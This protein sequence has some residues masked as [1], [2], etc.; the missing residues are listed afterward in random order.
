MALSAGLPNANRT[1]AERLKLRGREQRQLGRCTTPPAGAAA[2]AAA[3][4]LTRASPQRAPSAAGQ[5]LVRADGP[6]SLCQAR[7]HGRGA[8]VRAA[9]VPARLPLAAAGTGAG[10]SGCCCMQPALQFTRVCLSPAHACL[11]PHVALLL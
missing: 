11:P 7:R 1:Y 9:D 4:A 5:A 6:H 2:G 3:A 8:C 10:G